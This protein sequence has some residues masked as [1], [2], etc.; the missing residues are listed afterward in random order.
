MG[1][2]S[3]GRLRFGRGSSVWSGRCVIRQPR[4][5]VRRLEGTMLRAM[6]ELEKT[7]TDLLQKL[8]DK[9]SPGRGAVNGRTVGKVERGD[10]KNREAAEFVRRAIKRLK[11]L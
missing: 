10:A 9:A 8:Q 11:S 5:A 1:S 4:E 6:D 7:V 2:P 3:M